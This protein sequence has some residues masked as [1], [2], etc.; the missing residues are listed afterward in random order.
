M[1]FWETPEAVAGEPDVMRDFAQIWRSADKIVFSRTLDT[2][3]SART[4]IEREFSP[5]SVRRLKA[6]SDRD[7]AIGGPELAGQAIAAGLVDEFQL[8]LVPVLVGGGTAFLPEGV[9]T[10]LELDDQHRFE[11]G[12]VYLQY[13]KA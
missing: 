2:A 6:S 13:R 1:L 5:D 7:L 3:S 10:Q 4:R 9:R 12:V 8:F 11:S